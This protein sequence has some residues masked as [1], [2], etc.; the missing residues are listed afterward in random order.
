MAEARIS[1]VA[2]EVLRVNTETP[3]RI[4]QIA[5][6]AL[7]PN[8]DAPTRLSQVFIQVL[9]P[10]APPEGSGGVFFVVT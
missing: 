7:R 5:I 10:N 6:E 9:R 1:Q 2:V 3:T 8:N 4:H